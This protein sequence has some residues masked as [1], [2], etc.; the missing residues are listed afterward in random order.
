MAITITDQPTTDKFFSTEYPLVIKATSNNASI[1]YLKFTIT[2][3]A[4]TGLNIPSYYAPQ[5]NSEF[6]FNVSDYM[7]A[8]LSI[9]R[10]DLVSYDATPSIH[11]YT[12]LTQDVQIDIREIETDGTTAAQAQSNDFFL[13]KFKHQLYNGDGTAEEYID[14]R[15][16]LT[17]LPYFRSTA[18][19][20]PVSFFLTDGRQTVNMLTDYS[21]VC[22][23]NRHDASISSDLTVTAT[24]LDNVIIAT[25]TIDLASSFVS[26]EEII[27]IPVNID[28]VQALSVASGQSGFNLLGTPVS[29]STI[30]STYKKIRAIIGDTPDQ[31]TATIEFLNPSLFGKCP[32]TFIYMNRFGVHEVLT[33]NTKTNES[34]VSSRD[35]AT[36]VNTDPFGANT[37]DLGRYLLT[38]ARQRAINPKSEF[39]F[40]VN[41]TLPYPPEQ[42][43]EI[44][45]DFFASPVHYCV[46]VD[47]AYGTF[48][49]LH[50]D[51]GT[52][53][54]RRIT[55]NDGKVDVIKNNRA[56][57][58]SFSYRY[59][60]V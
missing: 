3:T 36:L 58:L 5:I 59:A 2:D 9:I 13:C 1:K 45:L 50:P 18:L 16:F 12:N 30:K 20:D 14:N 19:G 21:R 23:F 7:N 27:G 42:A 56:Q 26:Q 49:I 29:T 57:R 34:V 53:K 25:A 43:R 15:Y 35:N 24:S 60:D 38:G 47:T 55:I 6:T 54:I 44:A 17:T 40:Q 51:T 52:E 37:N 39:E 4:T 10:D 41:N 8:Y 32:K 31:S 22:L 33:L 48:D 11:V 46:D 28:D